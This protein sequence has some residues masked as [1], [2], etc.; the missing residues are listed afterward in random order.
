MGVWR[1]V[2]SSEEEVGHH[3]KL[4]LKPT[5]PIP[6]DDDLEPPLTVEQHDFIYCGA[7]FV[8]LAG[9]LARISVRVNQLPQDKQFRTGWISQTMVATIWVHLRLLLGYLLICFSCEIY[10]YTWFLSEVVEWIHR[11][12]HCEWSFKGKPVSSSTCSLFEDMC[13]HPFKL[14]YLRCNSERDEAAQRFL[15]LN[16]EMP[17]Q[18]LGIESI[19][20]PRPCI[21]VYV[22]LF[23]PPRSKKDMFE[24]DQRSF[25]KKAGAIR[26]TQSWWTK[27]SLGGSAI[28]GWISLY[29]VLTTSRRFK[30]TSRP[31]CA[32][33]VGSSEAAE[34]ATACGY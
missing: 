17:L 6:Q 28:C 27:Q 29:S 8:A 26:R 15:T 4:I 2:S 33:D 16:H 3:I 22:R 18:Q 19:L 10:I 14:Y 9:R 12:W 13:S 20:G 5:N 11:W 31:Q 23:I 32:A 7:L 34:K 30:T 21:L 25:F 1:E 24:R